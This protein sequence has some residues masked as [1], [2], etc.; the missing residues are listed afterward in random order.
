MLL[1][2]I[3]SETGDM[4]TM[5]IQGREISVLITTFPPTDVTLN[6]DVG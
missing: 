3:R 1:L 4:V 2:K 5:I 6:S